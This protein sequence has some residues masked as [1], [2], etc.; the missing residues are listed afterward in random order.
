VQT[1]RVE[2]KATKDKWAADRMK[3][4]VALGT[5]STLEEVAKL[6]MLDSETLRSYVKIYNK[7]GVKELINLSL[8]I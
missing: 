3:A 8:P 5:G 2:H 6:L 1:L 4:V 7:E